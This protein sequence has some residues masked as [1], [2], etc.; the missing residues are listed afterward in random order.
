M[1]FSLV[2]SKG[3]EPKVNKID[4]KAC[5]VR[6]VESEALVEKLHLM[7]VFWKYNFQVCIACSFLI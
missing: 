1:L 2:Y 3:K 4:S 5:E 6:K 7:L